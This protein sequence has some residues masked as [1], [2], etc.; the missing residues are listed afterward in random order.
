MQITDLQAA[1]GAGQTC[2]K[3]KPALESPFAHTHINF[4]DAC[5]ISSTTSGISTRCRVL[6]AIDFRFPDLEP[7][8]AIRVSSVA[9]KLVGSPAQPSFLMSYAAKY[10]S[11]NSRAD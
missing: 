2:R 7:T 11:I 4:F 9:S 6:A 3:R 10:L 1:Q 5:S 8:A